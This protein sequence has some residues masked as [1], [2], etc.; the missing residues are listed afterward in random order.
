M[1]QEHP[2]LKTQEESVGI[3]YTQL[4]KRNTKKM[5]LEMNSSIGQGVDP[6]GYYSGSTL[7]GKMLARIRTLKSSDHKKQFVGFFLLFL[8]KKY[9]FIRSYF[10]KDKLVL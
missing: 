3:K 7:P 4:K 8:V 2:N 5:Y 10:N 6:Y 1:Y 9:Y